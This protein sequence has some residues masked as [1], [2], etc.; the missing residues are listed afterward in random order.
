MSVG[1]R[2]AGVGLFPNINH[3]SPRD[4]SKQRHRVDGSAVIHYQIALDA[5]RNDRASTINDE[6]QSLNSVA[7]GA[8]RAR[9]PSWARRTCRT[10]AC[11]TCRTSAASTAARSCRSS[12]TLRTLR[13]CISC[14][15]WTAWSCRS[16]IS[17]SFAIL[18]IRR[19][20]ALYGVIIPILPSGALGMIFFARVQQ[21]KALYR[22][23]RPPVASRLHHG[24]IA[25]VS[26][27]TSGDFE[28]PSSGLRL[29]VLGSSFNMF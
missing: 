6:V 20:W 11:W 26:I 21:S 4:I 16:S 23:K 18:F 12:V 22:L 3:D 13:A 8:C 19:A 24:F 14:Y 9:R 29:L 27:S 15:T 7:G 10:R 1:W 25:S 5:C 28:T 17:K 2:I